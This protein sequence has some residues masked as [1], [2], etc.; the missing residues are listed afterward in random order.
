MPI[1]SVVLIDEI[2][3]ASRDFPND[4]LAELDRYSTEVP[5]L[6]KELAAPIERLPIVIITSNAERS[7]PDAFL[8]R[9]LF[10][11]MSFPSEARLKEIVSAR[12]AG[13]QPSAL[14]LQDAIELVLGLR[15]KR[16]VI[17]KPPGTSELLAF[18]LSLKMLNYGPN[19][20]LKNDE[21]WFPAAKTTLVKSAD[22]IAA[23]DAMFKAFA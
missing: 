6:A 2:D 18:I 12:I 15:A 4:V 8:R 9:C 23:A 3:K 22:R 20:S 14:L 7:L 10:H 19:D 16:T 1:R 13:I 5:E 11:H 21:R 17:G